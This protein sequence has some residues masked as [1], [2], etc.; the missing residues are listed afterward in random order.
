MRI[1]LDPVFVMAGVELDGDKGT[2]ALSWF[3]EAVEWLEGLGCGWAEAIRSTCWAWGLIVFP[4]REKSA[5]GRG[6]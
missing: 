4:S 6:D 1:K 2:E 3:S 5:L